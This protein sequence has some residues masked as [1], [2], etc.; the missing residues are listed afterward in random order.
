[1]DVSVKRNHMQWLSKKGTI[2]PI[3]EIIRAMHILM[4][5]SY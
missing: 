2:I 5:I 1:M 3:N 4:F